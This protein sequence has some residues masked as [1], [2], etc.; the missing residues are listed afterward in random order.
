[1]AEIHLRIFV[2]ED[3]ILYNLPD[4]KWNVLNDGIVEHC[5]HSRHFKHISRRDETQFYE[6]MLD[7]R[8]VRQL[9]GLEVHDMLFT[10]KFPLTLP[11]SQQPKDLRI[12]GMFMETIIGLRVNQF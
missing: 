9:F 4:I 7:L 1:M 10:A 12:V 3:G 2:I 11:V 8:N 5:F 6:V